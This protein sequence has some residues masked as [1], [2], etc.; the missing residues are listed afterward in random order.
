MVFGRGS[1]SK[2]NNLLSQLH[3]L[4]II[5]A[6]LSNAKKGNL[7]I[8]KEFSST[9]NLT[10]IRTGIIKNAISVFIGELIYRTLKEIEPNKELFAFLFDSI[11]ELEKVTNSASD[12]HPR[13]IVNYCKHLGYLPEKNLNQNDFLFEIESGSFSA[14]ALSGGNFFGKESSDILDKI[15]RQDAQQTH[16]LSLSGE[17]RYEFISDMLRYIGYHQ[18][19]EINLKSLRVLHE[20]FE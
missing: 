19:F 4:S 16:N 6:E 1:G 8:I 17:S 14:P 13:F 7:P 20:V 5:D 9:Q 2:K 12:F 11:I 15:L 10:G 3:P 18:G